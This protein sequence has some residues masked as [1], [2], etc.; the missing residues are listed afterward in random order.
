MILRRLTIERFRNLAHVEIELSGGVTLFWGRNAQGKTNLLEAVHYLA[1]GRS[2]RTRL[3]RECLPLPT[4]PTLLTLPAAPVVARVVGRVERASLSHHLAI[5]LTE[6]AKFAWV[7]GKAVARLGD[8]LG[9]LMIVLFTPDDIGIAAGA[10]AL[11]RRFLDMALSQVSAT[12]LGHL[13]SYV[14]ALRQRNAA[15]RSGDR[16]LVWDGHPAPDLAGQDARTASLD[17]WA[18]LLVEHGV[19]VSLT[20]REAVAQ[21]AGLA[22][23]LYEHIAPGDGPLAVEWRSGSGLDPD[24]D[25]DRARERFWKRLQEVAASERARGQTL[26]GPHRDDLSLTIGG[27]EVRDYG[28]QGQQRS[29][30]LALR[31]AEVRWMNQE[32]GEMPV[33]LVDDLGA[34]LDRDRRA[35]LLALFAAGVQTLATTAGD[36]EI[37]GPMIGA[38]RA[39]EVRQGAVTAV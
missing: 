32:T 16:S 5:S 9:K 38:E 19:E 17:P 28:S 30:A 34:E 26:V 24:N 20:R 4:L 25:R 31:L 36:A 27:R 10:P 14:E 13:Q 6:Q 23:D 39:L 2:F 29:V 12:Y 18:G 11:R 7:D 37:L 21:L 3:D 1:T 8:L 35:R 22:Y 15:L 33:L